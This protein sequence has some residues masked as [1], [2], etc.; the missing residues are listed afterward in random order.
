MDQAALAQLGLTGKNRKPRPATAGIR[1]KN[2][3]GN[4]AWRC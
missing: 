1:G 3:N 2:D 4:R